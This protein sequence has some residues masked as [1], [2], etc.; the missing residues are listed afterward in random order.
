[1]AF[2]PHTTKEELG[3]G[4][5][6]AFIGLSMEDIGEPISE[7]GFGRRTV[8]VGGLFT[9]NAAIVVEGSN[10]GG[11]ASE[12]WLALTD[13][14]GNPLV[15]GAEGIREVQEFSRFMRARVLRGDEDTAINVHIFCARGTR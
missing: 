10:I 15:F 3:A 11:V 4:V 14:L 6:L 13:R 7:S 2:K 1:M 8:Q 9:G 5:S 12:N